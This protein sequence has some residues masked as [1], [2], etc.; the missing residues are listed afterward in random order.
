MVQ[1]LAARTLVA[2]KVV[3]DGHQA[4]MLRE[5]VGLVREWPVEEIEFSQKRCYYFGYRMYYFYRLSY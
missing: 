4:L 2:A 3:V 5:W 1:I